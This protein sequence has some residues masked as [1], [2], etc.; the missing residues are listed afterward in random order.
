MIGDGMFSVANLVV[1]KNIMLPILWQQ[2]FFWLLH[3]W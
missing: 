2:I 3:D 1:I